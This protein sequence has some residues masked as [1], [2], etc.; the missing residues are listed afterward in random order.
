MC[1]SDLS[2]LAFTATVKANAES[3]YGDAAPKVYTFTLDTSVASGASTGAWTSG[4]SALSVT[5]K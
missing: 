2:A 5:K 3:K 4:G 1:S